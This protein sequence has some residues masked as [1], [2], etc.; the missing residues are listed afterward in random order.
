MGAC[1]RH[2]GL[3]CAILQGKTVVGSCITARAL[4]SV[5]VGLVYCARDWCRP[6]GPGDGGECRRAKQSV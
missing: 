6:R 5:R 3:Q 2:R 1:E 4:R